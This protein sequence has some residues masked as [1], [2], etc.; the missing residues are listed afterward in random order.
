METD[1]EII[2]V[3]LRHS[4]GMDISM[5]DEAFLAKALEK[6]RSVSGGV[7]FGGYCDRLKTDKA[8]AAAFSDSLCITFSEFFRN[9]LTFAVLEKSIL[10]ALC[11]KKQRNNEK[12]L[13]IWSAACAAGQEPYS[14][15]MLFDELPDRVK[16]GIACLVFATDISR[17]AL[18]SAREGVYPAAAL[19]KTTRERIQ[20]C[21]T[22]RGEAFHITPRIRRYVDFA[23]FD[24]LAGRGACP[25]ASIYGD[26]DL[27]FCGNL[28]FYYT[29]EHQRCILEKAGACLAPDGY[30]ITGEAERAIARAHGL[31]EV[32]ENSAIFQRVSPHE[33]KAYGQPAPGAAAGSHP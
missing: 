27:V 21:F 30:L 6:R 17:P 16:A 25:E 11:E 8:E 13:R 23:F 32:C 3:L 5:Y 29:P 18:D 24:L 7:S 14:I 4:H 2:T 33:A 15:A 9:P 12:E 20:K 1:L 31:H 26:F 28:L 19:N 10:P 22:P